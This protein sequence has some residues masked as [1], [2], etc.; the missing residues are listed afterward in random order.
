MAGNTGS[1]HIHP[2][3]SADKRR[4]SDDTARRSSPT[5]CWD[6]VSTTPSDLHIPAFSPGWVTSFEYAAIGTPGLG[7][8][9][10]GRLSTACSQPLSYGCMMN[11]WA[12]VVTIHSPKDRFYR[13]VAET[14]DFTY[15]NCI[16]VPLPGIEPRPPSYQDDARAFM[17][18]GQMA[19]WRVLAPAARQGIDVLPRDR[20]EPGGPACR[21]SGESTGRGTGK[22]G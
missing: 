5:M 17:V 18:Q 19:E 4:L 16:L 6:C 11:W 2:G 15:P 21:R 8:P 22:A 10:I 3:I 13:P 1:R 12:G 20:P 14:I 9:A 7:R